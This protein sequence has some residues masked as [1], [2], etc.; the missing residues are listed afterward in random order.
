[1]T[2]SKLPRSVSVAINRRHKS[3]EQ[4]IMDAVKKGKKK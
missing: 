3:Q 4:K 1:M 2:P